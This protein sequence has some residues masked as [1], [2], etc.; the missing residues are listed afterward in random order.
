MSITLSS[1]SVPTL[2]FT[3]TLPLASSTPCSSVKI[4]PMA[5]RLSASAAAAG[6]AINSV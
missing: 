1:A 2:S 4:W 5:W 6:L 3:S